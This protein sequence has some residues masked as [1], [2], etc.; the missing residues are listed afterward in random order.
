MLHRFYHGLTVLLAATSMLVVGCASSSSDKQ[1]DVKSAQ[2][3]TKATAKAAPTTPTVSEEKVAEAHAHYAQ[4][5]VFDMQDEPELALE[6]YTKSALQDPAN[7]ELVLEISRRY[8]QLKQTDKALEILTNAVAAPNASGAVYARLG[9]VYSRLGQDD[10]ALQS[11][12]K[13]I[14]KSPTLLTGYQNLF[15]IHLQKNHSA[16]AF[17]VLDKAAK[18]PETSAEFLIN[19][20]E[21]FATLERQVPSL[22]TNTHKAALGVLNRAAKLKPSSLVL[23][24]KLAD[25]F[26]V[27]GDRTNALH[28]YQELLNQV[29][30][31]P[32]VQDD[33]RA[34]MAD[35]YLKNKEPQ[36][37]SEQLKEIVKDDPANSQAYYYL[38]SLA[39]DDKKLPEA[40][41]FF[42]KVLLLNEEMEQ[43]YYDL[44]GVQI[45]LE[46]PKE[47]LSTLEHARKKFK[48][49]F[50][51]EF[52][53]GLAFSKEKDFTNALQHLT[54]AEVI[55]KAEEP[56][57]LNALF[58]F[59]VGSVYERASNFEEAEKYFEKCLS[60]SPNFTEALNY[61]GY[62][63]AEHGIKLEKARD[64]IE[65]AVKLEP[66]NPAYLD[67]FAWVLYKLNQPKEALARIEEAIK[68]TP[69]PDATLYD[70]LGDI[71][72]ALKQDDKA[73]TAWRRSLEVE[74]NEEVRKKLW[75]DK[76]Q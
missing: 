26:N 39:Y 58:Y 21:L 73:R 46:K 42:H 76:P 51:L 38:G 32:A 36:K 41:D 23:R 45:N 29:S 43:A 20:A 24:I 9:M 57:R 27:L 48:P 47:A 17:K 75:R 15:L 34:K 71:Y 62:M 12:E 60:Q 53:S 22:Q 25:G 14:Q 35:I 19:L 37:A 31:R 11:S 50:V 7:D 33:I 64:L 67:S 70:H 18:Q 61:L 66:K 72:A 54:S 1:G 10:L 13:A 44:A 55:A 30:S 69:E 6:E 2:V 63:W 8:L 52:F 59:E 28:F 56:K 49:S 5:V 68:L 74:Q 65:K 3:K 4:G 16:E 40:E